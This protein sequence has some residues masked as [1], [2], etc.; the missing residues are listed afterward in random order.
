[1][2]MDDVRIAVVVVVAADD[3]AV[4]VVI[5]DV[6]KGLGGDENTVEGTLRSD[7]VPKSV[8]EI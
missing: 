3:V 5:H 6:V 7:A 4:V 8:R 2:R 1:M